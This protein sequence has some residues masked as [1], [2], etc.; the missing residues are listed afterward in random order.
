MIGNRPALVRAELPP[1]PIQ[2]HGVVL[3][4]DRQEPLVRCPHVQEPRRLA[5][6]DDACDCTRIGPTLDFVNSNRGGDRNW[7]ACDAGS[8]GMDAA[9][10]AVVNAGSVVDSWIVSSQSQA[11]VRSQVSGKLGSSREGDLV[12]LPRMPWMRS[13]PEVYGDSSGVVSS[14]Q[15]LLRKL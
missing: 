7:P 2:Q 5:C 11:S 14:S 12:E 10:T 9:R 6:R 8:C 1:R 4:R 3:E 15:A 13:R